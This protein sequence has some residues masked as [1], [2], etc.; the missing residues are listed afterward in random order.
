M[1]IRS[2]QTAEETMHV[3]FQGIDIEIKNKIPYEKKQ[4][5]A[6]ELVGHTYSSDDDLGVMYVLPLYDLIRNYLFVKYY[7]NLDISNIQED[8]DYKALYDFAADAGLMSEDV[9]KF[10]EEDIRRMESLEWRY[11][12]AVIARYERAHSLEHMLSKLMN[13]DIDTSNEETRE[14]IEKL[15]DMRGALLEKENKPANGMNVGGTVINFA[16]RNRGN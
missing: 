1:D 13:A 4:E 7:T 16:K 8:A 3:V 15:I 14:L 5:F 10:V 12:D 9:R 11:A 6:M 2:Y